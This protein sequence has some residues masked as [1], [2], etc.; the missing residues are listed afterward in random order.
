MKKIEE[1]EFYGPSSTKNL[2]IDYSSNFK[3]QL[4][5]NERCFKCLNYDYRPGLK[6]SY[7]NIKHLFYE[8]IK[9]L[10]TNKVI[11]NVVEKD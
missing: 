11:K 10:L 5:N 6:T 1:K 7:I 3:T 4:K 2:M 9:A 8:E